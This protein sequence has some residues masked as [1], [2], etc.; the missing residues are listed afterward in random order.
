MGLQGPRLAIFQVG[1]F[2]VT[3]RSSTS[4]HTQRAA[5]RPPGV[6][7]TDHPRPSEPPTRR[8]APAARRSCPCTRTSDRGSRPDAPAR[9]RE[10]AQRV[11]AQA[12]AVGRAGTVAFGEL[13]RALV[14]DTA[15]LR[16]RRVIIRG[17]Q[18]F[19]R[20]RRAAR[21]RST[22]V[23]I[24]GVTRDDQPLLRVARIVGIARSRVLRERDASLDD[25]ERADLMVEFFSPRLRGRATGEVEP[26][27]RERRPAAARVTG[28]ARR[29]VIDH[30]LDRR[31]HVGRQV[32]L[33]RARQIGERARERIAPRDA[34]LRRER[35]QRRL[36]EV[37]AAVVQAGAKPPVAG[38]D[39]ATPI[40]ARS[41]IDLGCRA[42]VAGDV[43]GAL[44]GACPIERRCGFGD[45]D[46]RRWRAARARARAR[47]RRDA[48]ALLYQLAREVELHIESPRSRP[49]SSRTASRRSRACSSTRAAACRRRR[50]APRSPW[51]WA[52]TRGSACRQCCPRCSTR[53]C[54]TAAADPSRA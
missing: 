26:R 39:V 49:A 20:D 42:I 43:V 34:D 33:R 2:R 22:C 13:G 16:A 38:L 31:H 29:H 9:R 44:V 28:V 6:P 27:H 1:I 47:I 54:S 40:V 12:V 4:P 45:L 41:A 5:R 10:T 14:A 21:R 24:A 53:R 19:R 3:A 18:I 25:P 30:V 35:L 23:G 50:C 37:G 52:S 17:A 8:S 48:C 7:A 36:V 15:K 11:G 51:S 46:R 32:V